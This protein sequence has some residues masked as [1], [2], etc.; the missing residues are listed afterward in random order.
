V[1]R[2]ADA[3]PVLDLRIY[4]LRLGRRETFASIFEDEALPMLRRYEIDVVGYGPSLADA[5]RYYLA[6]A[7]ASS[8][9][10]EQQLGAFYGSDEWQQGYEERVMELIEAFHT[11]VIP[12]TPGIAH[13][14]GARESA[15]TRSP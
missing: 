7:F 13:A 10:R 8:S 11:V 14:L 1:S 9:Q 12:L 6:R 4:K 2:G 5:D 3:E 15:E